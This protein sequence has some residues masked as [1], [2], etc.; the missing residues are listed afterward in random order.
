MAV[1]S[2]EQRDRA[3]DLYERYDFSP[4]AVIHELGYPSEPSLKAWH[5][6]REHERATGEPSTR[7]ARRRRYT[8]A[9]KHAAVDDYLSHGRCMART[10]RR[11]GYPKSKTLLMAW[12]DE[13]A[14]GQRKLRH[15]PVPEELKRKAVV[16]VASGRL[17]SREAAAEL[18]VEASVVRNWKRQMLAG[19]KET[20]VCSIEVRPMQR[21]YSVRKSGRN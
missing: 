7:G 4:T 18:G 5:R 15:G 20:C 12:I 2:K 19:S 10:M 1:Y 13:L 17:K 16:A 3:V 6:D 11:L 8:D 14:P 9:Q 21:N